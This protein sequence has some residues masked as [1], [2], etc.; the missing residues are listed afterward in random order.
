MMKLSLW[1]ITDSGKNST[2]T[3]TR[4]TATLRATHAT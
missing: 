3:K 1:N 4:G 2:A